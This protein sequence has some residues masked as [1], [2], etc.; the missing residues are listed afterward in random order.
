MESKEYPNG[1]WY[2]GE[3]EGSRRDGPGVFVK[4]KNLV[5]IGNWSRDR[6]VHRGVLVGKKTIRFNHFSKKYCLE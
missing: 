4:G 6:P 2:F 5:F 1:D 3:I